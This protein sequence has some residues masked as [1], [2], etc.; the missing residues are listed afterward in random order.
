[1]SLTLPG[2]NPEC[3][4][5]SLLLDKGPRLWAKHAVKP[6]WFTSRERRTLFLAAIAFDRDEPL[7]I[8]AWAESV[9]VRTGT[10]KH[11][12]A[13]SVAEMLEHIGSEQLIGAYARLMRDAHERGQIRD[14]A[15]SV[16]NDRAPRD[17]AELAELLRKAAEI[18]TPA[19]GNES[20]LD[21][22][23]PDV[24]EDGGVPTGFYD[25]DRMLR[26]GLLPGW[27]MTVAA[28]TSV[29]KT[30]FVVDVLRRAAMSG[31]TAGIVSLEMSH[32]ALWKRLK[33]VPFTNRSASRSWAPPTTDT[34]GIHGKLRQWKSEG[35]QLA[36]VDYL[37]LI[38]KP[39]GKSHYEAITRIMQELQSIA[40]DV[41]LP[42]IV[43]SQ[44]K[45]FDGKS[46]RRPELSDLRDSGAIEEASDQVV[47]LHRPGYYDP[48]KDQSEAYA[49]LAKNRHGPTGVVRLVWRGPIM[50]FGDYANQ[51][52][53]P[54]L[55]NLRDE[56]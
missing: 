17:P 25:I 31:I 56:F 43:V 36:V 8:A 26:G 37:Q 21:E 3:S 16:L 51:K 46:D 49:A 1:M 47:L 24:S 4:L 52:L 7:T 50:S 23:I 27:V 10:D 45:R 6:E 14:I 13:L 48:A 19:S 40:R 34:I 2:A 12:A 53:P 29:G 55:E 44:L 39:Q 38:R 33:L 20:P 22:G 41:Q 54:D 11:A 30:S 18:P 32:L 15:S 9:A 5:L 35:F 28:R 42:V